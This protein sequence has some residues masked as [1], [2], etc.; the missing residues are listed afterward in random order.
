MHC[1]R[2]HQD[3]FLTLDGEMRGVQRRNAGRTKRFLSFNNDDSN[4]RVSVK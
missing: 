2:Q 1:F 4:I 3:N